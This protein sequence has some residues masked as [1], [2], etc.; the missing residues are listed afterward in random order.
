M[1]YEKA[2]DCYWMDDGDFHCV[3][4]AKVFGLSDS[5]RRAKFPMSVDTDSIITGEELS[6]WMQDDFLGKFIKHCESTAYPKYVLQ[7]NGVEMVLQ[8]QDGSEISI[9]IDEEDLPVVFGFD[10]HYDTYCRSNECGLIQ[11]LIMKNELMDD[12]SLIVDHINRDTRDNRKSNLRIAN[13][14]QNG[15]NSA[16]R[17]NN[18][19][20]V[21]GVCWKQDK[22]KWKSYIVTKGKQLHIG[23]YTDFCEAVKA[24]LEKEKEVCGTFAPQRNLFSEYGIEFEEEDAPKRTYCRLKDAIAAYKNIFR[25]S[26]AEAGSGHDQALTGVIVQFDLTLSNKCWMEAERYHFLDFVSSQSTMHRIAKFD[27]EKQ[28]NKYVDKKIVDIMK[29]KIAAYNA[30]CDPTGWVPQD[31]QLIKRLEAKKKEAYL[32]ILYSNPA[33]FELTGGMTT[34]YRQLKTI[35]HQRKNH[36]L[37][38][39]REFCRWIE[40]L[41]FSYLITGG[42]E[43]G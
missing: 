18:T 8:K 6:F 34:N 35:Y 31:Q 7:D 24:R 1:S 19:T 12:D 39:W 28:Y 38:E 32:E 27:V 17:K 16:T 29:E 3:H 5:I 20:G 41:P 23:Y 9:F 37:P 11:R 33:G 40:T 22:Q 2:E 25:L 36:R 42:T 26:G 14:S 15:Y 43:N 10:W 21:M 30:L 13:K 4:N